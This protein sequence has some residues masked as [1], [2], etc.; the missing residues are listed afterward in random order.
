MAG[1]KNVGENAVLSIIKERTEKGPFRD[2]YDFLARVD[3]RSVNKRS[4][5]SLAKAGAFDSFPG[6]HRAQ[7]FYK[8]PGEEIIFLE[9]L[10][11]YSN[12]VQAR[13]SSIQQSLFGEEQEILLP[14][15]RAS[16]MSSHEENGS[17]EI[18]E[19][20]HRLLYVRTSFG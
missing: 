19:R 17:A 18:R 14:G 10:I 2:I 16:C 13:A 5:E 8:I 11:R 6:T 3:L 1:I 12:D 4:L 9:K 7:Y 20:N 15:I